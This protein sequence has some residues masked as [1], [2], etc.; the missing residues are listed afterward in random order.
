MDDMCGQYQWVASCTLLARNSVVPCGFFGILRKYCN[1]KLRRMLMIMMRITDTT[2]TIDTT[3]TIDITNT[4]DP[5]KRRSAAGRR[6]LNSHPATS[7][8]VCSIVRFSDRAVMITL[9]RF[10]AYQRR[11]KKVKLKMK[12]IKERQTRSRTN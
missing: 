9:A 5:S 6:P 7:G 4:R 2:N 1:F 3:D 10:L 12:N 11:S 8:H